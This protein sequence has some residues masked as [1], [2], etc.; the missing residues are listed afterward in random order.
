[1]SVD[2]IGRALSAPP[3]PDAGTQDEPLFVMQCDRQRAYPVVL[4]DNAFESA[5]SPLPDALQG[6]RALIVTTRTVHTLYGEVLETFSRTC[7]S[8]IDVLVLDV[9]EETK[10]PAAIEAICRAAVSLELDRRAVLVGVGGGICTDLT[11]YAAALIRRGI[12]CIRVPTTVIGQVDAGIGVKSAINFD[13]KK[14]YL[15]CFSPPAL[16]VIDPTFLRTLPRRDFQRGLAEIV[17]IALVRDAELFELVESEWPRFVA[18]GE[19]ASPAS[20]RIIELSARR[21]LEE[22][23]TNLFEDRTHKRLVDAGHTFSPQIEAVTQFSVHHGEAVAIDLCL[24]VTIAAEAG[25]LDWPSRNRVVDL[26]GAIG[27]PIFT[28]V[29]SEELCERALAEAMRHRGGETNLVLPQRIGDGS[30]IVYERDLK[31]DVLAAAIA[32]LRDDAVDYSCV[33][34]AALV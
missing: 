3:F 31:P 24:S 4:L 9:D 32:R 25:I 28:P 19:G 21:M 2:P 18:C 12:A 8:P 10:T 16:V 33:A 14:S 7:D 34:D 23:Q 22:L 11:S 15:G 20:T 6:R 1:M 5:R 29:L 27:L 26:I 17:K 30:C 13:G